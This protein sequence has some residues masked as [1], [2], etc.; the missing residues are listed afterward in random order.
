MLK[1]IERRAIVP[2]RVFLVVL[3]G[4]LVVFQTLSLP[5]QFRH[6][7]EVHPE[8]A[9]WRW[10]LTAIAVF[11]V[12]CAQVIVF[13]TWKLLGLMR[14]DRIFSTA[15]FKWVDAI[16]VAAGAGWTVLFG[17]FLFI[18]FNADDPGAPML[19][20]LLTVAGAVV[21]LVLLVMRGLLHQAT[22]LRTDLESV[23]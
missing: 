15:A 1:Q 7:A 12:L 13:S 17:I 22:A 21:V 20:F 9:H 19:F 8:D 4:I 16:V 2:L 18:G 23:I 5:G 11:C 10:P 6:E 3:F 14:E